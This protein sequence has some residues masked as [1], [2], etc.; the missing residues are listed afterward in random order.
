MERRRINWAGSYAVMKIMITRIKHSCLSKI[1]L[2]T[3][4]LGML[5]NGVTLRFL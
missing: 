3:E 1:I 5:F 4:V 2:H